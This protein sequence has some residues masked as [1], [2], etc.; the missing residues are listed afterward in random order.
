MKRQ[1]RDLE[2]RILLYYEH[3]TDHDWTLIKI[4]AFIAPVLIFFL[5]QILNIN[6]SLK[7]IIMSIIF[8]LIFLIYALTVFVWI[9]QKDPGTEEMRA[10]ADSITEGS[11]GFFRAQYGTIF[12]LS[13]IFAFIIM[14]IYYTRTI[15]HDQMH[16]MM[17][18]FSMALFSGISFMMGAFC[19]ALSGYAG[20]WV[21]VRANVR[22]FI[23]ISLNFSQK[24][25]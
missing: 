16:Q 24:K 3:F 20:M 19:S 18:N 6:Y 8:A 10:L 15:Q 1:K 22:Y 23:E 2:D 14:I 12:K 4:S 5:L 13:F 21:S 7:F 9:I 25:I 17:S 11:E